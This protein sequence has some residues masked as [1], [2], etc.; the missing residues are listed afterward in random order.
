MFRPILAALLLVAGIPLAHSCP[1]AKSED[2]FRLVAP[3]KTEVT[4]TFGPRVHAILQVMKMHLGVDYRAALGD[5]VAAAAPGTVTDVG[6]KGAYGNQITVRHS[7]DL[8]TTYSHLSKIDAAVGDCVVA[9]GLIGNA[10]STGLASKV[11]LHFELKR[12]GRLIDPLPLMS[13]TP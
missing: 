8:E 3:M 2:S 5:Q 1:L 4:S 12:D 13:T 11:Q 9:G 10:G 7:A 6:L